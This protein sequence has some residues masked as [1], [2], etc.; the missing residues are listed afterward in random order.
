MTVSSTLA[1][2]HSRLDIHVTGRFDFSTHREFRDAYRSADGAKVFVVNMARADY[3]DS[4]ALGM[5]LL[6]KEYATEKHA[7]VELH[8]PA[9]ATRKILTIANFDKL[10]KIT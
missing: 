8:A 5:L 2:D 7:T 1:T 3:M 9:P 6:L 4:S 10:F